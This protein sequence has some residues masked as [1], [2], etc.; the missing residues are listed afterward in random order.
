MS[1][2]DEA[3]EARTANWLASLGYEAAA[4]VLE[5]G[6]RGYMSLPESMAESRDGR[7]AAISAL[8]EAFESDRVTVIVI[9]R[10]R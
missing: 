9:E 8:Q 4:H 10:G 3:F 7:E 2:P 6:L 1:I 5:S